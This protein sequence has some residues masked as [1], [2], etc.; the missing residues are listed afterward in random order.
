MTYSA[1]SSLKCVLILCTFLAKF[2][3]AGRDDEFP[4][5]AKLDGD[6]GSFRLAWTFDDETIIFRYTVA[7]KGW[8]SLAFASNNSMARSDIV[9]VAIDEKGQKFISVSLPCCCVCYYRT[10]LYSNNALL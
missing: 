1:L 10:V 4:Y 9:V 8:A 7:T 5:K 2:C 6:D 3:N